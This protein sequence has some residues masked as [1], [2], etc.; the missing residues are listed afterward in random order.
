[1]IGNLQSFRF[2]FAVM[3]FLHHYT[4]NGEGLFP[5]G[6]SCGVSFF[7]I[8]SGFVMSAGYADKVQLATFNYTTFIKKRL[9]RIYPLHLLCLLGFVVISF[10]PLTWKGYVLLIPNAFLLQSWIPWMPCYFS[11]NAVSW[12][13]SDMLF[14]YLAFPFLLRWI[15]GS[16]KNTLLCVGLAV[17]ALYITV[18]FLLPDKWCHPLLYISPLFRLMDFVIGILLYSLYIRMEH[19]GL[20]DKLRELS[21][22]VKSAIE[23]VLALLLVA[24]ILF[25][26]LIPKSYTLASYWWIIMAVAV[27]VFSL[28]NKSGGVI[29][30][31]LRHRFLRLLGEFSFTFYMIHQLGISVLKSIFRKMPFELSEFAIFP[32]IFLLILATSYVVYRYFEKPVASYLTKKL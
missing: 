3:I 19:N 1:M 2:L 4:I 31:I 30:S 15:K 12:C 29:S 23:I 20:G 26:P 28:F 17:I 24:L 21:F 7:I 22:S 11:G 10:S 8:L 27:S 9:I 16:S 6:G 13:L 25:Y 18:L 5:A 14:F 32:L